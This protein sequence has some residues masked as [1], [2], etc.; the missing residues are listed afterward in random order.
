M[1]SRL[2]AVILAVVVFGYGF[3]FASRFIFHEDRSLLY[4]ELNTTQKLSETVS[5]TLKK[6]VY[7]PK[8]KAMTVMFSVAN[9]GIEKLD[10]NWST[11][12]RHTT[13]FLNIETGTAQSRLSTELSYPFGNMV[14]VS[15]SNVPALFEEVALTLQLVQSDESKAE[16]KRIVFY[17]NAD[18]VEKVDAIGTYTDNDYRIEYL[19]I[20]K[21]D[22]QEKIKELNEA[23]EKLQEDNQDYQKTIDELIANEQFETAEEIEA[24]NSKI[25]SYRRQTE[26]N[27]EIISQNKYEI[28]ELKKAIEEINA[29]IRKIENMVM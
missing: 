3:F 21:K 14:V 17:T 2:Y 15:I 24:T 25:Q 23:N 5:L 16:N 8:D 12:E 22:K 10:L 1:K 29:A 9:N 4:T 28:E 27:R 18:K 7:S 13:K 6:W 19:Q 20:E 11:T 26:R